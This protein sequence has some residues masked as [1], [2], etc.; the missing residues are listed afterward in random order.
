MKKLSLSILVALLAL[1]AAPV[2]GARTVDE[3]PVDKT[4]N[5]ELVTSIPYTGGSDIAFQGRWTYFGVLGDQGGVRILDSKGGTPKEVAFIECPGSQNDVAVVKPGLLALAYH[6]GTCGAQPGA[7][8]RLIDVRNPK[9]PRFLSSV[10]LPGGSHTITVYPGTSIL[11]SSPGGLRNG[12][13]VEQIID[14]SDPKNMKVVATFKPNEL[15][16]HDITFARAADG[17]H[18]LGFC[19]GGGEVTI[20]DVTKPLEPFVI[21]HGFTPSFFPHAAVPTPDGKHLVI[22]DE[23]FA[24]H[25]CA[26]GATGAMWVFDITTPEMPL[27]VG[28]WGPKRGKNPVGTIASEWCTAHNLNFVGKTDQAVVSWYTGG[29]SVVDFSNPLSPKEVAY[30]TPG[31]ADVWSAYFHE[32]LIYVNDLARGIDVLKIKGLKT[33]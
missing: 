20:W 19:A 17:D 24:A 26:S 29:T 10:E 2:A 6:S 12:G 31:D 7:G 25:D 28:H 16:C 14:A 22:T 18:M 30:F 9:K 8:V 27:L 21:S 32:G 3:A 33:K 1:S 15:G 5:V 11:Y 23:N 13:S 4:D